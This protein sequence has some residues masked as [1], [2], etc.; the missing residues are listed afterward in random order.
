MDILFKAHGLETVYAESYK[1]ILQH[2]ILAR[3]ANPTDN[4]DLVNF[5]SGS[6][7][8]IDAMLEDGIL[9]ESYHPTEEWISNQCEFATLLLRLKLLSLAGH[10]SRYYSWY[11]AEQLKEIDWS[12]IVPSG[13]TF[14]NFDSYTAFY[15]L[16]NQVWAVGADA[17]GVLYD[18]TYTQMPVSD[19]I[20]YLQDELNVFSQNHLLCSTLTAEQ[21]AAY[22]APDDLEHAECLM[23]EQLNLIEEYFIARVSNVSKINRVLE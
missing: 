12:I 22:I 4:P 15:E 23:N 18:Y 2:R 3:A 13:T 14:D 1:Y 10:P 7:T 11:A 17:F 9:N 20:L 16:E 19:E 8:Q 5:F 6:L 21:E